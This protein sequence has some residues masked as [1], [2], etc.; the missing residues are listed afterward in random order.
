MADGLLGANSSCRQDS[1]HMS[2]PLNNTPEL[3]LRSATVI[4]DSIARGVLPHG[5]RVKDVPVPTEGRASSQRSYLLVPITWIERE[6]RS[7]K[8]N[9]GN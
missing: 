7:C 5:T 8:E 6:M 1:G 3:N 9:L 4:D 2:A